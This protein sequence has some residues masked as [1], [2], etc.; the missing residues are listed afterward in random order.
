MIFN[1]IQPEIDPLVRKNR[2]GFRPGRSTVAQILSLR[3]LIEGVQSNNRTAVITFVD[4][5]K[6][7]DSVRSG[8]MF[9]ILKEYGI[10][11]NLLE[12]IMVMYE[13]IKAKVFTP[14]GETDL[15]EIVAGVFKG[16]T[17]S[18]YLFAIV[19]DY[20]M[21]KTI[22]GKGEEIGFQLDRRRSRRVLPVIVT[23]LDFSDD[24][25]LISQE[26]EATQI[27]LHKIET[28]AE[29]VG[30]H[31]NAKKTEVQSYNIYSPLGITSKNGEYIKEVD[32]YGRYWLGQHAIN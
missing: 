1:R 20:V 19:L 25:S 2:N 26:I 8:E 14:D 32:K 15:T 12:A 3:R 24:I 10:P 11:P 21:R 4:F 22:N 5:K 16:D 28:E 13:N 30:L 29:K 18:P 17:L 23:D 9:R 7:F 31:L 27:L 6:A